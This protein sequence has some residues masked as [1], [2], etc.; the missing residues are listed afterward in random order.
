[1]TNQPTPPTLTNTRRAL[2]F[3]R[4]GDCAAPY[5]GDF[6]N[7]CAGCVER[8]ERLE[9]MLNE[10]EDRGREE[11]EA[12][13]T[14]RRV[15]QPDKATVDALLDTLRAGIAVLGV[16]EATADARARNVCQALIGSF[17]IE[18]LDEPTDPMRGR[19]AP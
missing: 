14:S 9:R 2:D 3:V 12:R 17:A 18:S 19:A 11:A 13:A 1:M 6:G 16:D 8:A 10:A 5:C 7:L 15:G 4:S